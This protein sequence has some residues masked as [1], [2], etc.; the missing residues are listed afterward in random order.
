MKIVKQEEAKQIAHPQALLVCVCVCV[1]VC[2]FV[3][4]CVCVR[5]CV[6]VCSRCIHTT[7]CVHGWRGCEQRRTL[8]RV[9]PISI[10]TPDV[11]PEA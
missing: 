11:N 7:T 2:V 1:C 6:C 9:S 8:M 5:V 10:A 4:V 3:F